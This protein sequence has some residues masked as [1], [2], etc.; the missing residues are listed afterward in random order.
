MIAPVL[1]QSK[2]D[3]LW[4]LLCCVLALQMILLCV[5]LYAC[6]RRL[7]VGSIN[8]NPPPNVLTVE[9]ASAQEDGQ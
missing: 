1:T 6:G 9:Q 2:L 8:F 4:F 3:R 7:S 5:G